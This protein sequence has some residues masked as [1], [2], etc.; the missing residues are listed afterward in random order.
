MV[1][2]DFLYDDLLAGNDDGGGGGSSSAFVYGYDHNLGVSSGADMFKAVVLESDGHTYIYPSSLAQMPCHAVRPCVMDDLANRHVAYYLNPSD[3]TKKTDGTAADLT[4]GD[5][6][7]MVEFPV[8]YYRIDTYRDQSN[9]LHE[10]FLMSREA[11]GGA[12]IWSGFYI[13]PGGATAR[14]QF[15]GMYQGYIEAGTGK[16]RS[17]SGVQPTVS[18]SSRQFNAAAELN[19]GN[20]TNDLMYQWIFH[21]LIVEHLSCNSQA[22]VSI[23][24]TNMSSSSW[25]AS[26]ARKTG[27]TNAFPY[28][29]EVLADEHAGTGADLDL[30]GYWN[31]SIT[32]EGKSWSRDITKDKALDGGR[33]WA[34]KNGSSYRWTATGEP[35]AGDTTYS[36][37]TLETSASTVTALSLPSKVVGCK[38]MIENP[39]GSLWA[40]IAG[41][42]KYQNA[43]EADITSDGVQFFRYEDGD[44]MD[45][46]THTSYAWKS[47]DGVVIYTAAS[48]PAI[49]SATFSDITLETNRGKNIT[50]FDDDYSQS[51]Y[52]FTTDTTKYGLLDNS[53]APLAPGSDHSHFPA[54]GYTP[55]SIAWVSHPFPKGSGY[56]KAWDIRN[57]FP[58]NVTGGSSTTY[59]ADN[60]YNDANGGARCV[61]RG[62]NATYGANAGFGYVR[63]SAAVGYA[64]TNIGGRLSA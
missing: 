57:F 41:Y 37:D 1:Y 20:Q 33:A 46:D 56:V 25:I 38:Y 52:W 54:L 55:D 51:G 60:F 3:I 21:L 22:A 45:G 24:F 10:V 34:W 62:G 14:N 48:H 12:A 36:D 42:Q 16:L 7:V 50:A 18:K 53:A 44:G 19:G 64:F 9:N 30:I 4:G 47:T 31:S 43:T 28:E 63:V 2:Y 8:S 13:S 5:G 59:L 35:A 26:W 29:G 6:D 11:F 15:V 40:Q 32:S 61:L 17:I 27:R 23:G 39:W 49:G 58:T